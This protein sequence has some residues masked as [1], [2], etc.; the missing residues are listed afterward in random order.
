MKQYKK[1]LKKKPDLIN[2]NELLSGQ[3]TTQS[4]FLIKK[5]ATVLKDELEGFKHE[6]FA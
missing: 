4:T 1:M 2:W 3:S 5:E 6:Q